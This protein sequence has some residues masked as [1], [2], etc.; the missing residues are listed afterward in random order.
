MGSWD[1]FDGQADV[2]GRS[3]PDL[4]R[5]GRRCLRGVALIVTGLALSLA[6]GAVAH[7]RKVV[8]PYAL[9]IGWANEPAYTGLDNAVEVVVTK[10]SSGVPLSE[11]MGTMTAQVSFGDAR[12]ELPLYPTRTPGDFRAPLVPTRAGTYRFHI[13]GMIRGMAVDADYGCSDATFSCVR[14]ASE[15]E[16][17][18]RDPSTGELAARLAHAAPQVG[19][20]GTDATARDLAIG[21][22]AVA[23]VALAAAAGLAVRSRGAHR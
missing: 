22:I 4:A 10:A 15:V 6:P 21:A 11:I 8:G 5:G 23:A 17:P 1:R 19:P 20:G 9:S 7:V 2:F 14:D 13:I 3:G 18:A 16:F 12:V